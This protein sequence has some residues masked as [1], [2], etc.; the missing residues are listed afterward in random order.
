MMIS[1]LLLLVCFARF[2]KGLTRY[3]HEMGEKGDVET[4]L[5]LCY[6]YKSL[7]QWYKLN[8]AMRFTAQKLQYFA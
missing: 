6:M 2:V 4:V 5:G 1:R 7:K 8:L 3:N